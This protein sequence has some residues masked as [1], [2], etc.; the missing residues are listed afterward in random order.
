[1][2]MHEFQCSRC[3]QV[4][5]EP[6]PFHSQHALC[7][8]CVRAV[9]PLPDTERMR[10]PGDRSAPPPP[11]PMRRTSSSHGLGACVWLVVTVF[12]VGVGI[13]FEMAGG[14]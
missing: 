1:M 12:L 3:L 6:L 10:R 9:L 11:P 2:K 7:T 13:G 4:K 8:A 5:L 14:W